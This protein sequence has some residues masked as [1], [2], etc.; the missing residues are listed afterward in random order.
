RKAKPP[1]F[2][3]YIDANYVEVSQK[4]LEE[5][6]ITKEDEE[7]IKELARDPWIRQR[8]IASIAPAIYGHWDIKEA[9][10]LALF[11]GV[12]KQLRD[13]TRVRGDIHVL[14]IGDPGTAKSL[15]YSEH[16]LV[17]DGRGLLDSKPIGEVVDE[18]MERFKDHVATHGETE[19]LRLDAV[20]VELY[21]VAISPITF[22]P[23]VKRIKALIRHR[24]PRRVVVV[25]TRFGRRAV[26]TKEHSLIGFDKATS[27]LVA[28]RP[29]DALKDKMLVPVLRDLAPLRRRTVRY[30]EIGGRRV[31]LDWDLGYLLGFFLGDGTVTRVS[32]GERIEMITTDP[33]VAEHLSRRVRRRLGARCRI[34]RRRGISLEQYRLI[35]TEKKLVEWIKTNCFTKVSRRTGV[36]GELARHKKVPRVAFNA[37]LG[38]VEGMISGLIDSDGTVIPPKSK[39]GKRWRGEIVFSTTSSSLAYGVSVLLAILGLQYTIRYSYASY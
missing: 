19:E 7:R 1:V 38:F 27:T 22:K 5:V 30:I 20:G 4:V 25:R 18:Y 14:L 6:A 37:P 36:K 11:G 28:V 29:F 12:P 13:G 26:I 21:T 3:L 10:T 23:E 15:T 35:I 8:I 9:I 16:I 32:S 17:M 2:D 33:R 31:E 39:H 24:A 34:Y